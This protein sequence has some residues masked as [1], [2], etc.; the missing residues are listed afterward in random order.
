M[1]KNDQEIEDFYYPP[2]HRSR[3]YKSIRFYAKITVLVLSLLLIAA[4]LSGC[5]SGQCPPCPPKSD[6]EVI[7]ETA[8]NILVPSIQIGCDC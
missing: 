6:L 8:Q 3:K 4:V 7:A 5:A 1:F 2:H